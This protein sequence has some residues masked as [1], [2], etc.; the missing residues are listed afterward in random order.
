MQHGRAVELRCMRRAYASRVAG[1]ARLD[2]LFGGPPTACSPTAPPGGVRTSSDCR[3]P[4]AQEY[5]DLIGASSAADAEA[6]VDRS[7]LN[8]ETCPICCSDIILGPQ[9]AI[10]TM[11]IPPGQEPRH[12]ECGHALHSDCFAIYT[13]SSGHACPV[14]AVDGSARRR[15][16]ARYDEQQ[17]R[18]RHDAAT[19]GD[20][21]DDDEGDEDAVS[22]QSRD[23]D[24]PRSRRDRD[25]DEGGGASSETT[26]SSDE[27]VPDEMGGVLSDDDMDSVEEEEVRAAI[28]RSLDSY[29]LE[30][31]VDARERTAG[32]DSA[33]RPAAPG[34]C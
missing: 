22:S 2:R 3:A 20:R 13:V 5:N 18:E 16:A 17:Q 29:E 12:F 7:G 28:R 15:E 31:H 25:L 11:T 9:H 19:R 30:A 23:R 6:E 32:G 27:D 8:V 33:T 26:F 24:A 4:C 10:A 14:C 1:A 34:D 21:W